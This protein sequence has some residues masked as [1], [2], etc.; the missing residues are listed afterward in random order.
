M[1]TKG[2][3]CVRLCGTYYWL[4]VWPVEI[5]D[6]RRRRLDRLVY[7]LTVARASN[8]Q[9]LRSA[10]AL[11]H[12]KRRSLLSVSLFKRRHL[13]GKRFVENYLFL[14][15]VFM[16]ISRLLS[17]ADTA[18]VIGKPRACPF[19]CVLTYSDARMCFPTWGFRTVPWF[20]PGVSSWKW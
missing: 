7:V 8:V 1:H 5:T 11:A 13:T 14:F 15:L 2:M 18:R 20:W 6:R 4:A 3:R 17:S 12:A 9:P 10:W 16:F 19:L